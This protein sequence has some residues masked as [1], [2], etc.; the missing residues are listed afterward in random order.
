MA[1]FNSRYLTWKALAE[2][3]VPTDNFERLLLPSHSIL[4]GARGSGKTTMLKMLHPEA[5]ALFRES[6]PGIEY[7]F[8]GVYIPSDRQW[9]FILEELE[10]EQEIHNI[11]NISRCLVNLNVLIAFLDS[12]LFVIN[13]KAVEESDKYSFCK[14]LMKLW[15]IDNSIPPVLEIIRMHLR[16]ESIKIQNALNDKDLNYRIP[17]VC[18]SPFIES[19]T[20]LVDAITYIFGK[21]SLRSQW[22]LCFDE[23]EIAPNWL[24]E[25]IISLDLRS[26]AQCFLFKI[27]STPDWSIPRVSYRDAAEN[28]DID[29]IKCW[30]A[31]YASFGGWKEFCDSIIKSQILEKYSISIEDFHSLLNV[32]KKD[33][34]FFFEQLPLVDSG[35]YKYFQRDKDI[36]ANNKIVISRTNMRSKYYPIMVLA[37]RYFY[38]GKKKN[39]PIEEDSSYLGDWLLYN[40]PD[41]NPRSFMNIIKEISYHMESNGRLR[42]NIPALCKMVREF[43][44]NSFEELFSYCPMPALAISGELFNFCDVLNK[45]GQFFR[46]QLLDDEYNPSP[47]TMFTIENKSIFSNFIHIG[48]SVGAIVMIGDTSLYSGKMPNGVYRL[49]YMLYPL[50][51]I[52]STPCKDVVCLEDIFKVSES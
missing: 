12:L 6:H 45:I 50:F 33:R 5:E 16:S 24:K 39:R 52:V 48:L 25:E 47:I 31:E 34:S 22:A 1:T 13:E 40:M 3:F 51:G 4:L 23:M 44:L 46:M 49:S 11:K 15:Q 35:F 43:S 2:Q 36:D 19:L 30:N 28:N 20:L 18:A 17:F 8:Y 29:I 42:M 27:T 10:G 32:E 26:R 14:L 7:P 41:G 9:S 38:F 21:Y 37:S